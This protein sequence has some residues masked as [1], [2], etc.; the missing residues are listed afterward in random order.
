M[1]GIDGLE[2]RPGDIVLVR[3][4]KLRSKLARFTM[5]L[6]WN[7]ALL[8]WQNGR[9]LELT[10]RGVKH[11][12]FMETYA[13]KS[14]VILRAGE[15]YG[16][17]I[18]PMQ[19]YSIHARFDWVK[20]VFQWTHIP[21]LRDMDRSHLWLMLC[22][23]FIQEIYDKAGMRMY[24]RELMR[25]SMTTDETIRKNGFEKIYDWRDYEPKG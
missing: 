13:R 19:D 8:Y 5:R 9:L 7:H 14:I 16:F 20:Y 23:E 22:D 10:H 11:P 4:H 24:V 6:Y 2:L 12:V 1:S 17:L 18:R 25:D 15:L 21:F 3:G